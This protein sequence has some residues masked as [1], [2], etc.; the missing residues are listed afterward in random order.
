MGTARCW[1]ILIVVAMLGLGACADGADTG[2][3]GPTATTVATTTTAVS[4]T[5][6]GQPNP[7]VIDLSKPRLRPNHLER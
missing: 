1:T 5:T 2:E 3:S 7:E 6:T 4:P